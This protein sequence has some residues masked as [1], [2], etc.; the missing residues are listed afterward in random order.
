MWEGDSFQCYPSSFD[1]GSLFPLWIS[2][3]FQPPKYNLVWLKARIWFGGIKEQYTGVYPL[4]QWKTPNHDIS[5]PTWSSYHGFCAFGN[6]S[7]SCGFLSLVVWT[8]CPLILRTPVIL[9][10]T[11][12]LLK[13]VGVVFCHFATKGSTL[14][15]FLSLAYLS[16]YHY[17]KTGTMSIYWQLKALH[18]WHCLTHSKSSK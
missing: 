17:I 2:V 10:S 3:A 14:L 18:Q 15:I 5:A 16:Q 6:C 8:D 4:Q 1:L 11:S 7:K 13:F 9:P 12:F